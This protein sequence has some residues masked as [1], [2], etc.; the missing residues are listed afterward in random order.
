MFRS[1]KIND[2]KIYRRLELIALRR[3]VLIM[4]KKHFKLE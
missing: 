1:K 2:K 3:E 4:I